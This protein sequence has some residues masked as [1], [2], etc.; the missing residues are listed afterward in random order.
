MS[1]AEVQIWL[2][3]AH[4]TVIGGRCTS[5]PRNCSEFL[6]HRCS[7]SMLVS[8]DNQ[9]AAYAAHAAK[10][11][12]LEL[13]QLHRNC[14]GLADDLS[15]AFLMNNPT[16]TPVLAWAAACLGG[17]VRCSPSLLRMTKLLPPTPSCQKQMRSRCTVC[18]AKHLGD[19]AVA[20]AG[21]E[22]GL[23]GVPMHPECSRLCRIPAR[24]HGLYRLLLR[25][26]IWYQ[27]LKLRQRCAACRF[28]EMA[29]RQSGSSVTYSHVQ[30]LSRS[31][32]CGFRGSFKPF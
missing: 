9:D 15:G 32:R 3:G 26:G 8:Y 24:M 6:R 23:L 17:F 10:W 14:A 7:C 18:L 1:A 27:D 25:V 31:A 20:H 30:E 16:R 13:Q 22:L 12:L 4:R 11:P 2:E 21:L 29:T 28:A 19:I 5:W